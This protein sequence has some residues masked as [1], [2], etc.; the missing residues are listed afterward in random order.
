MKVQSAVRA[1]HV[2]HRMTVSIGFRGGKKGFGAECRSRTCD[3]RFRR[4]ALYPAE[5]IPRVGARWGR[6]VSE[7]A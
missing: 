1:C 2:A 4:P 3:L 6:P 5:L 7:G